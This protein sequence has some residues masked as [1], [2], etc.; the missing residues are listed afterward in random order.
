LLQGL[1]KLCSH[2]LHAFRG[3][4]SHLLHAFRGLSS[5][6]LHVSKK[7]C[8]HFINTLEKGLAKNDRKEKK[9]KIKK[10]NEKIIKG[11]TD[12]T[13]HSAKVAFDLG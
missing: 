11:L 1:Q 7:L 5:H 10:I 12:T 3:L 4:S 13:T 6:L 9:L 8:S 2:L